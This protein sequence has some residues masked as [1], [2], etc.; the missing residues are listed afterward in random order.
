M[1]QTFLLACVL[2]IACGPG[3]RGN[4]GGG[5][6]DDDPG[7][8]PV[9][10]EDKMSIVDC[11]GNVTA[12]PPE[13]GCSNGACMPA[14]EAAENNNSSIGCEYYAVDM[15]AAQGPPHDACFAVFIAN[16]SQGQ[17]HMN[18]DFNGSYINLAQYAKIPQGQGQNLTYGAYD[19]S[20]GLAPGQVAIVFLAY[21]PA[22]SP[23]MGNV[24][25]PVPAAIGTEA[26]IP[27]N[28]IGKAFH[29]ETDMPVV[30]YQMLPYGG[31]R[32][33]ATRPRPVR[34]CCCRR[35]RGR[36][37]TSRSPRTIRPTAARRPS[38]CPV[39]SA[40]WARR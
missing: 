12:C 3:G 20:T 14:C 22:G 16:T 25:C 27:G 11:N 40:R 5:G 29:I 31:G 28:G 1:K 30:A 6:G 4:G 19:P 35:A 21:A 10:S 7:A 15:D 17:A 13:Q 37:T 9:C 24:K 33:A 2:L 23:L 39:A 34:R 36:P 26:Q 8:C 38:R 18:I 32:A